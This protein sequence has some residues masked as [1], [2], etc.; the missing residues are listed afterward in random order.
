MGYFVSILRERIASFEAPNRA[1]LVEGDQPADLTVMG[2]ISINDLRK[3]LRDINEHMDLE[4][5]TRRPGT[6]LCWMPR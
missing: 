3:N 5:Q 4:C 1:E 6:G 2:G